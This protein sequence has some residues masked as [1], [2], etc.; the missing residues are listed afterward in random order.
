MHYVKQNSIHQK[1]DTLKVPEIYTHTHTHLNAAELKT[2]SVQLLTFGTERLRTFLFLVFFTF[3]IS[4][5]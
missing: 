5:E 1:S 2:V 4:G 3:E